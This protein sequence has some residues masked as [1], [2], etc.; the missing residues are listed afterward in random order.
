MTI[1]YKDSKRIVGTNTTTGLKAYYK[2]EDNG[3]NSQTTGVGLGADATVVL[4]GNT[5]Y[6]TGKLSKALSFDGADDYAIIGSSLSNFNFMHNTTHEFTLA[7]W[8]KSSD[9]SSMGMIFTTAGDTGS[10]KYGIAIRRNN[11]STMAVNF[12]AGTNQNRLQDTKAGFSTDGNWHHIVITAKASDSTNS[13][14]YWQDG[15]SLGTT[16]NTGK[17]F[18]DTNATYAPMLGAETTSSPE[19]DLNGQIDNLNI[20]NRRLS[21]AEIATLYNSGTGIVITSANMDLGGR[22][23]D[24]QDNSILV[25]KDTGKRYWF[26]AG[27][28]TGSDINLQTNTA[29]GTG[30]GSNPDTIMACKSL[31]ELTAGDQISK[32][33]FDAQAT[34]NQP[35]GGMRLVLYTD[36]SGTPATLIGYTANLNPS[37]T[38]WFEGT[39][40][41]GDHTITAS[42]AG[43]IWIGIWGNASVAYFKETL[44]SGIKQMTQTFASSGAP[45]T[46]FSVDTTHNSEFKARLTYKDGTLD[47]WT[48]EPTYEEDFSN[49]T[50]QLGADASWVSLDTAK[51]RVNI[52]T[53]KLDFNIVRDGTSDDIDYDFGT[54]VSDTAWVLRYKMV[55]NTPVA[56]SQY[57]NGGSIGLSSNT[58]TNTMNIIG[59]GLEISHYTC[60]D[61]LNGTSSSSLNYLDDQFSHTPTAETLYV[62]IIR[63]SSTS[64]TIELFS[65]SNYSTSV[66]KETVTNLSSSIVDLRY[67]HIRNFNNGANVAGS[68]SG[69]V[70]NIE[71]YNGVT[72]IN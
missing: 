17:V 13:L 19:Q 14:Q 63:T 6:V 8:F 58:G 52:T 62:E 28:T 10:S 7:F 20:W 5:S 37:G 56:P 45:N 3:T 31:T 46:T 25:E 34:S 54:T 21:D 9:M 66:E 60:T 24:V 26:S 23:T 53:K 65:D 35:Y 71:L 55:M 72:S 67:F 30:G 1:E 41:G 57:I 2:F 33:G 18:S 40:V 70:D 43:H 47:T 61:I 49:Y 38:G 32:I 50:T 4:S 16:S 36:N 11:S 51:N 39:L 44:S 22:P 27:G 29:T 69:T 15:V 59:L 68:L 42:E 12:A 48:M 64:Y